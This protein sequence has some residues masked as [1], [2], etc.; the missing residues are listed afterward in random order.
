MFQLVQRQRRDRRLEVIGN[1]NPIKGGD[2][3][4]NGA[5]RTAALPILN[6][7]P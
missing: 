5:E 2:L 7:I 4:W 3:T 6:E 1:R